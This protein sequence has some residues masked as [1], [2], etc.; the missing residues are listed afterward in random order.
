MSSRENKKRD[1][2]E[3]TEIQSCLGSRF[4]SPPVPFVEQ[5]DDHCGGWRDSS[6]I[7][8]LRRIKKTGDPPS[9]VS[10]LS[11][12]SPPSSS[13]PPLR[14]ITPPSILQAMEILS[15]SV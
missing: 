6:R 3:R 5:G 10:H 14:N 1:S 11:V 9:S 15:E 7:S 12:P 4:W 13:G 2:S 8:A